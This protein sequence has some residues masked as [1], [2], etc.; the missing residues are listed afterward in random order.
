MNTTE[1]RKQLVAQLKGGQAFVPLREVLKNVP[2]DR[3]NQRPDGMPHSLWDLLEHLRI[4]QHD[5]LDFSTNP[6]YKTIPWPEA[7]W[8]KQA[9]PDEATWQ[10]TKEQLF[11]DLD[12]MIKL[13]EDPESDLF[14]PFAH[15]DGQN[16][17]RE[18]LLV[19]EHNAYHTGQFVLVRRALGLWKND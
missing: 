14:T 13:V 1:L 15:G 6:N 19:G 11:A 7:Y 16:L 10:R 9:C 4:T 3:V 8:P 2:F 5:I 12:A 17:L 18:A